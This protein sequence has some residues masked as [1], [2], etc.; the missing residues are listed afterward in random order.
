MTLWINKYNKTA[1]NT[2]PTAN[3]QK[4]LK[5]TTI[6]FK[7]I[8]TIVCAQRTA[9][10]VIKADSYKTSTAYVLKSNKALRDSTNINP[11]DNNESDESESESEG[12]QAEGEDEG[13]YDE[14]EDQQDEDEQEAEEQDEEGIRGRLMESLINKLNGKPYNPITYIAQDK[15]NLAHLLLQEASDISR[16]KKVSSADLEFWKLAVSSTINFMHSAFEARLSKLF[17]EQQLDTMKDH[18][19]DQKKGFQN[20][21]TSELIDSLI[22]VLIH[23]SCY[24]IRNEYC[25]IEF[26]RQTAK[27]GLLTFQQS[28]NIRI[29]GAILNDLIARTNADD[30]YLIYMDFWGTDGYVAGLKLFE[31][32]HLVHQ[33]GSI[34]FPVSLIEL[35]DFRATIKLLY[36]IPRN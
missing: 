19:D 26:K 1:R 8:Y 34:H 12:E 9:D 21:V 10:Q 31:N 2:R 30:I 25:C 20:T 16:V 35:K 15:Q 7:G 17:T 28:K 23:N 13:Q 32:V 22:D 5:R 27:T 11:L 4:K 18:M 29:N 3:L 24:G 14:D 36:T 6:T 33:I